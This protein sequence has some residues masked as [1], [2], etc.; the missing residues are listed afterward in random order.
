MTE[1]FAFC[2]TALSGTGLRA[3]EAVRADGGEVVFLARDPEYYHSRHSPYPPDTGLVDHAVVCDT[4]EVDAVAAA[5]SGLG[6]TAVIST[7]EHHVRVAAE[8]AARI[9]AS[10]L[11]PSAAAACRDKATTYERAAARGVRVP[12]HR[13]VTE[14]R[15]A[16]TAVH[17][18]SGPWVVKPA[19]GTG[20]SG[21]VLCD[22][23]TAVAAAVRDGLHE[24][25][26]ARGQ[27]R[28]GGMVVSE[29]VEGPEYSVELVAAG[30]RFAV[31]GVTAKRLGPHPHFVELGHVF[32]APLDDE[33]ASELA[34]FATGAA[35]AVGF[36]TGVAH[37]ELR[38][39]PSG[40]VLIEINARPPGDHITDLVTAAT[41]L[42]LCHLLV[43]AHRPGDGAVAEVEKAVA[44][45]AAAI[46]YLPVA[47]PG[48]LDTI[49]G[50]DAAQ[51][52]PGVRE[53]RCL[54]GRNT[55]LGASTDS[56]SRLAYALAAAKSP[57]EAQRAADTALGMLRPVY[58]DE[59]SPT[60]GPGER[61]R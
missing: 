56:H 43:Q 13:R 19:D 34:G 44:A 30:G 3:M 51:H 1:R 4:N 28:T 57:A 14:A 16:E 12:A 21:V 36:D 55:V 11:A 7:G 52:V 17:G 49:G 42:D 32:P 35:A 41:G 39:G 38:C 6:V 58:A 24:R 26:N 27:Y 40:P 47:R 20:S 15:H 53:V 22:T 59:H 23:A 31:V 50:S 8:A 48:L 60:V 46:S 37:V 18:L 2:E 54:V 10:G 61:S 33:Q 25:T 5:L 9:G 45:G 29:Y